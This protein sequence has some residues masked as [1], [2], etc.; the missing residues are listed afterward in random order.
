MGSGRM[1]DFGL[2]DSR[3][4]SVRSEVQLLAG[5]LPKLIAPLAIMI[6]SGV[7]A[8]QKNGLG[9]ELGVELRRIRLTKDRRH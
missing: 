3:L 6:V 2:L 9:V 5:P 8:S 4:I 1:F 7:F